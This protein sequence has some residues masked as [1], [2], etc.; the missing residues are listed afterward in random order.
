MT[1]P[2]PMELFTPFLPATYAV[3]E[4]EDKRRTFLID[5][6]SMIADVVNDKKIG[7]YSQQTENFNGEKWIFITTSKVRNGY[8]SIAYI[9]SFPNASTL[10]LTLFSNPA[11][12]IS[13]IT[14]Q[15]RITLTWGAATKP[16]SAVGAG[17][18]DYITFVNAG[19][20]K[21]SFTQ[22][23]TT[24]VITTTVDMTAYSG[25]ICVEYLRDGF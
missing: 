24:I 7:S 14:P 19:N 1:T 25:F 2:N 12:P 8:Q 17:D 6:F 10:T 11:Y 23:D 22:S 18:G 20:P 21:I 16:C 3:P 15:F 5:K 13:N 4:E 9:P